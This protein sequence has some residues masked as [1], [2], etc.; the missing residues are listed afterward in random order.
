MPAFIDATCQ[1]CGRRFGWIGELTDS[2]PACTHC[3]FAGKVDRSKR[4][5][6][7]AQ[8]PQPKTPDG[9]FAARK[10]AG[11]SFGEAAQLLT[12]SEVTLSEIE[13]GRVEL[14]DPIRYR[15]MEVYRIEFS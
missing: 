15:M 6:K 2:A 3:G 10:G 8:S 5:V 14:I 4:K 7:P 11:L 1:H 9:F 13:D 12:V